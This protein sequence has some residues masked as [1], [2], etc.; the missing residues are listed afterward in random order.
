MLA[1]SQPRALATIVRAGLVSGVL[2][3]TDA[4]VFYR[5]RGVRPVLILQS[6]ASGLLGRAAFN[7]GAASAILGTLLHFTIAFTAS[8]VYYAASKKV[9]FLRQR[10]VIAGLLYGGAIYLF[11]NRIVVPLS[12]VAKP[13]PPGTFATLT[14]GVLAVVL[15][16]GLP[17]A[18]IVSRRSTR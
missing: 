18:L 12:A 16:V 17:I 5:L 13:R 2:D 1:T 11:M 14:N 15:L 7:G 3:L 9:P 4:L 10:P 6:I 8:A